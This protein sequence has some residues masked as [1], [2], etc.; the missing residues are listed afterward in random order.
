VTGVVVE[1]ERVTV[2]FPAAPDYLRLARLASAD[3]GSRAGFDMEE[4]DDLRI[5]V[6]ELVHLV[7]DQSVSGEVTLTFTLVDDT[8]EVDGQGPASPAGDN[9]LS[10][11]IVEA[12]VDEHTLGSSSSGGTFH[13]VKRRRAR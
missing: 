1:R 8:V 10:E 11:R 3:A 5:A 12:V 6:S 7:S 4:I 13:L 9:E 2:S